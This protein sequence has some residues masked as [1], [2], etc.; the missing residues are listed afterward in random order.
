[1]S[2]PVL[3]TIDGTITVEAA[4]VSADTWY[5]YVCP[6]FTRANAERI[7][8]HFN[9]LPPVAWETRSYVWQGSTLIEVDNGE[10][11]ETWAPDPSGLY[12]VG[13][14]SWTWTYATP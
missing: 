11:S 3:V 10:T 2:A 12:W 9:G 5:G 1:M 6:A 13:A 14:Y 8:D 4:G 7:A